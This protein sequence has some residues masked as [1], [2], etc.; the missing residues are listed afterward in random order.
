MP[1]EIMRA[2]KVPKTAFQSR[3]PA[4]LLLISFLLSFFNQSVFAAEPYRS[5]AVEE[6]RVALTFDDG[7]HPRLTPKILAILRRYDIHATF[8]MIGKN[9][10]DYSETAKMVAAEGHE[11]ANHTDSH[12]SEERRVGKEC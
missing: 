4:L 5:V 3:F 2:I 6:K 8:F 1:P 10:A 7:P 11:I 12:R 9:V